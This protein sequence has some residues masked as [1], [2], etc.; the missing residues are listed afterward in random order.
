MSLGTN[1]AFLFLIGGLI[2]VIVGVI[3]A[4]VV[5]KNTGLII[6]AGGA[7]LF[8]I[9]FALLFITMPKDKEETALMTSDIR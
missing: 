3:I 7:V 2:T 5:S 6:L 4:A 1:I 8:V 9:G